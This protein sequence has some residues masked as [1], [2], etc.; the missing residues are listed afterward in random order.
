MI[1]VNYQTVYVEYNEET[2]YSE[3]MINPHTGG[4]FIG[5]AKCHPDEEAVSRY[6]GCQLAENRA[7]LNYLRTVAA[8][9]RA[10]IKALETLAASLHKRG[11]KINTAIDAAKAEL[12]EVK[13]RISR[14]KVGI[15]NLDK[16]RENVLKKYV[17]DK[18][19]AKAK[20]EEN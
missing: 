19:I 20:N 10:V 18:T 5:R 8:E 2:G 6:F 9:K 3:V 11:K 1:N 4:S 7:F 14:L 13:M 15:R 17:N 16:Y 12:E